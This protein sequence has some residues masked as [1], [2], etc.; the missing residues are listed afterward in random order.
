MVVVI[1]AMCVYVCVHTP[2]LEGLMERV[3]EDICFTGKKKRNL[4]N[5]KHKESLLGGLD[6]SCS[7]GVKRRSCK[8]QAIERGNLGHLVACF[9]IN[10]AN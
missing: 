4:E 5:P 10:S 9:V 8:W 6:S 2:F 1:V 7:E 3:L